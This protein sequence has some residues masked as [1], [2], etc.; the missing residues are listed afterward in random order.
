M[1]ADCFF[2]TDDFLVRRTAVAI[3]DIIHDRPRKNKAV[4]HHDSHLGAQ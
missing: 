3:A 2:G 4:L 1:G